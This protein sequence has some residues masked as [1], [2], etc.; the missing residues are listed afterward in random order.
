M[1]LASAPWEHISTI[2]FQ[3]MATVLSR[4]ARRFYDENII[5]ELA[6]VPEGSDV[7]ALDVD[8]EIRRLMAVRIPGCAITFFAW[9]IERIVFR[10]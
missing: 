1:R 10:D 4:E 3:G 5:V 2:S 7:A 8:A 6:R 9:P